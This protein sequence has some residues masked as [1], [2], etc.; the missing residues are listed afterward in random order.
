MVSLFSKFIKDD[1]RPLELS[2]AGFN[3]TNTGFD[4][5]VRISDTPFSNLAII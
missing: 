5:V 2:S 4:V 3:A 1:I